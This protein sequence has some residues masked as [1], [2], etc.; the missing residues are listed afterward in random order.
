MDLLAALT[1]FG[2][3][4]P[5]E[6]PDK[7]FVATLVL[8]TRFPAL[9]VWIGVASAFAL[10]T[11]VAVVA[12]GL[13]GLLPDLVVELVAALLF[14]V[15]AILLIRGA[16]NADAEEKEEE[17]E[18]A[19]ALSKRAAHGKAVGIAFLMIF[20]AEWGDLS[21]LL[22]A[23]MVAQGRPAL[24]VGIGAWLALATISGMGVLIG[25]KLIQHIRLSTIRLIG[26]SVCALLAIATLVRIVLG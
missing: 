5:V 11:T 22:T 20:A 13:I 10:Q 1:A 8:A 7:T 18:F 3:I 14:S 24:S 12:G 6:L 16:R 25:R 23:G 2:V 21:Q 15:G 17:Q 4:F 9:P 26:G 19:E